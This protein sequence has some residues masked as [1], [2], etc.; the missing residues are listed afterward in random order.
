MGKDWYNGCWLDRKWRLNHLYY[1]TT[2][3]EGVIRFKLNWAQEQLLDNLHSRN[4]I[5][6]ARQ[7]GM[8]TLI[9]I[10][11]LDEVLHHEFYHAGI[12]DRKD[13]EAKKKLRKIQFAY[14]SLASPPR[15]G[16]DHVEDPQD[17]KDIAMWSKKLHK[18]VQGNFTTEGAT[19]SNK[20]DIAIGMTLRGDTIHFLHVSEFGYIAFYYPQR[21]DEIISGSFE[22][23]PTDGG[24]IVLES[25]HEGA[26]QGANYANLKTAMENAG[27]P[28][29]LPTDFKFH[30]FP[31]WGQKEYRIE[32]K[33][34]I[35]HRLDS[36]FK[37]LEDKGICLDDAQKRWY[38]SKEASLEEK[39]KK[40]YPSTPEEAFMVQAKGAIYGEIIAKLRTE[41]RTAALFEADPYLPLYVSWDLGFRDNTC[42]WL[43]QPGNDGRYYV[44]DYY[45]DKG[46]D[47]SFYLAKAQE[48]ERK[49]GQ[50]I[51]CHLVPHDGAQ[52]GTNSKLTTLDQFYAAKLP[53]IRIPRISD[54]WKG[55]HEVRMLLRFCVFHKRVNEAVKTEEETYLSGMECLEFYRTAPNGSN[56]TVRDQPLH[57]EAS[58]GADAFRMF[59]EACKHGFVGR[60]PT[61]RQDVPLRTVAGRV[62]ETRGLCKGVPLEWSE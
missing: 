31:W 37:T 11:I 42:M 56:G 6:K 22:S 16:F 54:V 25:T 61:Q 51:S 13:E 8:S 20:S 33:F 46:K 53:A 38:L 48:W 49:Y 59:A 10:L 45:C 29:L 3:N 4:N 24:V 58:H 18:S 19:F 32:S 27:K 40:E 60:V 26:K 34:P 21:A 14:E 7:M 28:E 2:K 12:I 1:I 30:F 50:L 5:L 17:R 23:V 55:I 41:G 43:I 47:I 62:L 57:D 15:V 9:S 36:Y 35:E 44:L 39:I 52:G